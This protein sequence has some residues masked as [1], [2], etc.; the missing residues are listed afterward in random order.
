M[1]KWPKLDGTYIADDIVE[2]AQTPDVVTR[3]P[4]GNIPAGQFIS[5]VDMDSILEHREIRQVNYKVTET[6]DEHPY[7]VRIENIPYTAISRSKA[8]K[9]LRRQNRERIVELVGV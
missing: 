4:D 1:A 3:F 7:R 5:R 8:K 9:Q 6:W 2:L